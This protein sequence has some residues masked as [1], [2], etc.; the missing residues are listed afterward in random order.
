MLQ[1]I[2]IKSISQYTNNQQYIADCWNEMEKA[3][4]HKKRFYHNLQHIEHLV[5][6]IEKHENKILDK[7]TMLFSAFY[8]D[9]VYDATA[10]DN[11]E[12]SAKIAV[13]SLSKTAFPKEKIQRCE[14]QILA[15]KRH[16]TTG[17][18]DTDFFTD[19]DLAILGSDWT[20]YEAYAKSIRKEYV[21]YPDFMYN[22]GRKKVLKH[23]LQMENI[24]KTPIFQVDLEEKARKNLENELN[25]L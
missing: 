4:T 15:T 7:E 18:F 23:F 14:T 12:Q 16:E 13:A 21:I 25:N 24:F 3:Y 20:D 6:C 17:D 2:F 9:I 8:H 1:Q 5:N 19:A 11:E 22:M 10:K